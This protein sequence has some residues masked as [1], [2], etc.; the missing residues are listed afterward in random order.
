MGRK[1]I[2]RFREYRN[3]QDSSPSKQTG[4][5]ISTRNNT[6]SFGSPSTEEPN[7]ETANSTG[8][9]D[10]GINNDKLTNFTQNHAADA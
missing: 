8:I 10:S 1:Q 5:Q 2:S 7:V 9:G 3:R 6:S 4:D